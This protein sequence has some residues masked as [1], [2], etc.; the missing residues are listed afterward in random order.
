MAPT[1]SSAT[2]ARGA[3]WPTDGEAE[4]RRVG[5]AALGASQRPPARA[6]RTV[7]GAQPS[8]RAR[9]RNVPSPGSGNVTDARPAANVAVRVPTTST[10]SDA[11]H[12]TP[13]WRAGVHAPRT[14]TRSSVTVAAPS[15]AGATAS[16][17]RRRRRPRGGARPSRG[18]AGLASAEAEA[19]TTRPDRSTT[20]AANDDPHRGAAAALGGERDAQGRDAVGA[21]RP[22]RRRPRATTAWQVVRV[23]E[24]EAL[25]RGQVHRHGLESQPHGA[26]GRGRAVEEAHLDA[27]RARPRRGMRAASGRR[28]FA[29]MR[30]GTKGSTRIVVRATRAASRPRAREE[31]SGA[32]SPATVAT[33]TA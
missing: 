6:N 27:A 31:A 5:A 14:T 20:S 26:A 10:T 1:R 28:T 13:P 17:A 19:A 21:R 2:G 15:A 23:A 4:P 7:A 11:V 24:Q 16:D 30:S 29:S 12:A 32:A 3:T 8:R 33:S 18:R 25:D 22:P 9:S